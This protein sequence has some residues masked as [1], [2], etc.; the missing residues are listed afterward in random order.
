MAKISD[1]SVAAYV[2][3]E[4]IGAGDYGLPVRLDPTIGVGVDQ[5]DPTIVSIHVE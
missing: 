5:L 1:A 2:D 4:G 3:L